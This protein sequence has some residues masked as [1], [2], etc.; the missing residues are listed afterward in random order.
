[1]SMNISMVLQNLIMWLWMFGLEDEPFKIAW[2]D[3][4]GFFRSGR[5]PSIVLL[6]LA[7]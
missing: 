1:M 5:G 3:E 7:L 4:V 2:E 6:Y